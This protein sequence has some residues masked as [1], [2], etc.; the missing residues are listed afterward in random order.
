MTK[1][2]MET[3]T[4]KL[5]EGVSKEAFL[6]TV[7]ASTDYMN[8]HPGFISRRLSCGEDGLWIEQIEWATMEDAKTAAANLGKDESLVPFLRCV[9]G[10][11]AA[12]RHTE[13]EVSLN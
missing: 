6:E 3:V 1:H 2:I 4:F 7:P 5:A 11:S 12:L 8:R 10:P 13:L 9:D